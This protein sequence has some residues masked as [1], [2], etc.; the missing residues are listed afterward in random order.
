MDAPIFKCPKC[1]L[2]DLVT[3]ERSEIEIEVC[4]SCRGVWLDRG[5]LDKLIER[6]FIPH[7]AVPAG[8]DWEGDDDAR[9]DEKGRDRNHKDRGE[10]PRSRQSWLS[11]LLD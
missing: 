1:S 3:T 9:Y 6:S 8:R 10:R 7:S 2:V 11:D 5:E 4:P